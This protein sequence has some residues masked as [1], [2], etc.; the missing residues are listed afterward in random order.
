MNVRLARPE[1]VETVAD[2]LDEATRWV[3][4]RGFEQWPLP[5]P[6][7]ELCAAVDRNEVYLVEVDGS[8]AATV[9]LL[10]DDQ[11]YWGARPPDALYVHKL[12][13]RRKQAGRRIG[14]AVVEWAEAEARAAG[15]SFLRLDCLADNPGI[16]R[17]YEILG[18]E[19]QGDVDLGGRRMSLY[20]RPVRP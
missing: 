20:E 2:L 15:R 3:G 14:R 16:R 4:K 18:F 9:T 11:M 13:V 8:A 5:F 17:Y 6:R 10:W 19:H 1:D 7:E 12:A